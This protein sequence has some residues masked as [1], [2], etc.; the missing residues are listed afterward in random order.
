[1]TPA[2]FDPS[3]YQIVAIPLRRVFNHDYRHALYKDHEDSMI[4]EARPLQQLANG[5][6]L[7]SVE[8]KVY[9][10]SNEMMHHVCQWS[11][12]SDLYKKL[13]HTDGDD[14]A[15]VDF[16]ASHLLRDVRHDHFEPDTELSIRDARIVDDET[17]EF[18]FVS[19]S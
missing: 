17:V 3:T 9:E 12:E 7:V 11:E 16:N 8:G 2:D 4:V 5:S 14:V 18:D 10:L 19:E 6:W 1:M 13:E 15:T